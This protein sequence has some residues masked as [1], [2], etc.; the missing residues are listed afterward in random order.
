MAR[1]DRP[2]PIP[3]HE[4]VAAALQLGIPKPESLSEQELADR[5]REVSEGGDAHEPRASSPSWL[6]VARHLVSSIVEQGLNLPTAARALRDSMRPSN[7]ASSRPPMP[8]VTLAQIYL[9]QGHEERARETLQQVLA[10]DPNHTKARMLLDKLDAEASP[11]QTAAV[12]AAARDALV[13]LRD[14]SRVVLYWELGT[15]GE[16]AQKRGG[17]MQIEV[18]KV[19]PRWHGA[20]IQRSRFDVSDPEGSVEFECDP[21]VVVRA[22][23]GS[24]S[25]GRFEVLCVASAHRVE[26]EESSCSFRPRKGLTDADVVTRARQRVGG[27]SA[28]D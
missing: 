21:N 22:A 17:A 7:R 23:L 25:N 20:E 6:A 4:L 15:R 18:A 2:V 14:G 9:G 11:S 28:D 16:R 8:T 5:I 3:R 26:A 24:T 27:A 13:V 19:E 1:D 12:V 10:R